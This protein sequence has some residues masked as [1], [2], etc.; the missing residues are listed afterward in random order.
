MGYYSIVVWGDTGILDLA[1][2]LTLSPP[3][4]AYQKNHKKLIL[5]PLKS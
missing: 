3:D 1:D 2:Y 4:I 5:F